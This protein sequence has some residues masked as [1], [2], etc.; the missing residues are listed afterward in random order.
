MSTGGREVVRLGLQ[1]V[2][3]VFG[4]LQSKMQVH[5]EI[6]SCIF[7][8]AKPGIGRVQ[9][10]GSKKFQDDSVSLYTQGLK[11]AFKY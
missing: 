7:R 3:V 1:L 6:W 5:I 9:V 8:V 10:V 2:N 4:S 11:T